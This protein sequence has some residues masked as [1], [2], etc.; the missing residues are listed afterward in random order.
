MESS[1]MI[2]ISQ[3]ISLIENTKQWAENQRLEIQVFSPN[4]WGQK[5]KQNDEPEA[6]SNASEDQKNKE[7]LPKQANENNKEARSEENPILPTFSFENSNQSLDST[8]SGEAL[9]FQ[10]IEPKKV[11][12]MEELENMA[13]REAIREF[14]GNLTEAAKALGIGRA[15]LYRKVKQYRI[16]LTA[17]RRKKMAS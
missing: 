1:T 10:K 9:P 15:T 6:L 14:N 11:R 5:E 7:D 2:L 16:D 3:D 17:I 8:P 13:I 12:T 4:E